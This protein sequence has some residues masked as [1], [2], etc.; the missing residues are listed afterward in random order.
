MRERYNNL[1]MM[2]EYS[3]FSIHDFIMDENFQRWNHHPT[4]EDNTFWENFQRTYP[5]KV[6]DVQKAIIIMTSM[7]NDNYEQDDAVLEPR[8]KMVWEKIVAQNHEE[9]IPEITKLSPWYSTK[10]IKI[11]ASIILILGLVSVAYF[12]QNRENNVYQS[13]YGE[14][15]EVKLPDGSSVK[16]NANSTDRK[17]TRLNSSHRNT[18]RMPSSA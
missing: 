8:M 15:K 14:S 12:Y 2:Q 1:F 17:S 13:A 6:V 4:V 18:S 3:N 10:W 7:K 11:A 16:L 9:E 5:H